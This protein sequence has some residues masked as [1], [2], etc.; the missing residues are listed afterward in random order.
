MFVKSV[1]CGKR[2]TKD[3]HA[4]TFQEKDSCEGFQEKDSCKKFSG[5]KKVK[6]KV[7]ILKQQILINNQQ[8]SHNCLLN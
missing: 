1:F 5:E 8:I 3:I 2:Y 6:K 7:T 4:K